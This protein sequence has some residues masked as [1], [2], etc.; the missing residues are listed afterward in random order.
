[1]R[2]FAYQ[3]QAH[4][5]SLL[6]DRAEVDRLLDTA[7]ALIGSVD[8]ELWGTACLRTPHYVEVQRA[9]CY[10]RLGVPR[11]AERIWSQILP[12]AP[13]SARRDVGVWSARRA[14]AAA[15]AG[16]PE[17]AVELARQSVAIAVTPGQPALAGSW[18]R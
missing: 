12:E 3:Q 15:A 9:T 6:N 10:G 11:E 2:V 4:G 16:E 14:Q 8:V 17:Q 1:M 5:A 18:P 7:G 13:P